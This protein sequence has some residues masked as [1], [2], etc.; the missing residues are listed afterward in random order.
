[1]AIVKANFTRSRSK[2]KAALRYIIHRPGRAGERL[3]RVLFGQ[4]GEMSKE[5]AYHLIDAQKG[6][7]YFHLKLNFHPQREDRRRDLNLRDITKQTIATLEERLHRTIRFL[8]VEH[9][10]HT[11]LRHIHAIVLVKLARGER[12]GKEEWK[13]CR[14]VATA[15]A[16]FQRRALEAI[17]YYHL[18][19]SAR[20]PVMS[21]SLG[22]SGGRARRRRQWRQPAPA[23]SDCGYKHPMVKLRDG[24]YWC[25]QCGRVEEVSQ[26]LSL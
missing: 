5:E 21:R 6:M 2:I 17:R 13:A 22:M 18:E 20:Q 23:C 3:T 7:T 15:Q 12:V 10:D 9:N 4:N 19:R 8:A 11:K 26:G 24:K 25:K 1:M 16:L 14:E